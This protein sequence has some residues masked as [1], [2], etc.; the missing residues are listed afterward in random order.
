MAA[1]KL[2][3]AEGLKPILILDDV[4]SEL[5]E[6][7]RGRLVE[8]AQSAEQ[9]FITVAVEGDLPPNIQASTYQ[10]KSGTVKVKS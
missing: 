4:F 6:E 5:D 10:V 9:T 1:Y 2:L 3:V 7:R 8:L